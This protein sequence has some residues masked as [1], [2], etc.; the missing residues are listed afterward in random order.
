MQ[1]VSI[2]KSAIRTV[3]AFSLPDTFQDQLVCGVSYSVQIL[4][5]TGM[6]KIELSLFTRIA[7]L[8]T[9]LQVR[10]VVILVDGLKKGVM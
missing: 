8:L 1:P 10:I 4:P 3:K 6:P 7:L 5:A 9:A 2:N